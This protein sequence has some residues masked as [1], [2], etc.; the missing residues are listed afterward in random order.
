MNPT[1]I[2]YPIFGMFVLT[3]LVLF[4]LF[5]V[6]IDAFKKKIVTARYLRDGKGEGETPAMYYASRNFINLFEVPVLFYVAC[7][8]FYVINRFD[9]TDISPFI[10][11]IAWIYVG[12]RTMHTAIHVTINRNEPRA[13]AFG[14]SQI[15][16]LVMWVGLFLRII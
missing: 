10:I 1:L 12:L 3:A 8:L 13:I 9:N 7:I 15:V 14:L 16:L 11:C 4:R 2:L 6:R 5:F